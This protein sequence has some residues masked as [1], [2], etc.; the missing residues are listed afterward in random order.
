MPYNPYIKRASCKFTL[1]ASNLVLATLRLLKNHPLKET[2]ISD[3]KLLHT[4]V[5]LTFSADPHE[6]H[7]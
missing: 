6:A 2:V 4:G 3:H 1:Q 5:T 7:F